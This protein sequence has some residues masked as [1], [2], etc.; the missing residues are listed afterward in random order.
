V[1]LFSKLVALIDDRPPAPRGAPGEICY[2]VGD[3]HGRADLLD[4]M[5]AAISADRALHHE[6]ARLVFL[7][8]YVDRGPD[9]AQ[10][11]E[12]LSR[13][14]L[15]DFALVFLAGNHEEALLRI[16]DGD[17]RY[18]ADWLSYGG[19]ACVRSYGLDPS[20]LRAM[21]PPAAA[22]AVRDAVPPHH[23]AFLRALSDSFRFGDYVFAHA[24]V[25]PGVPIEAQSARDLRWI[26]EGFLEHSKYHGYVVVHGHTIVGDVEQRN[27]RIAIDTGAYR[28]G[29]LSAVAIAGDTLRVLRV[30]LSS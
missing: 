25:R 21:P 24:G 17:A 23:L 18:L 2:A 12:R 19:D 10:V 30:D 16:V 3:I 15:P 22:R 13:L 11:I 8:D 26:R 5:L 27:N 20:R 7:G 1:G 14:E 6:A 4:M 9:S 28:T 29:R